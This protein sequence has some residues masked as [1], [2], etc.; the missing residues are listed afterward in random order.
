MVLSF[1]AAVLAGILMSQSARVWLLFLVVLGATTSI[2]IGHILAGAGFATALASA[3]VIS[4]VIQIGY[5]LGLF[6]RALFSRNNGFQPQ[7]TNFRRP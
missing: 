3:L 2:L 5:A 6:G 4:V 7:A 1:I